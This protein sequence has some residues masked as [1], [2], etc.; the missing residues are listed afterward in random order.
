MKTKAFLLLVAGLWAL[1]V[2]AQETCATRFNAFKNSANN[3]QTYSAA[4]A[5]LADILAGSCAGYSVKTYT[6][7]EQVLRYNLETA[8]TEDAITAETNTLTAFYDAWEKNF[9]GTGGIQKKALLLKERSLATNDEVFKLLDGAFAIHKTS[10]TDYNVLELYFNLYLERYKAGDKNIT[11]DEF[12]AKFGDMAGQV[13]YAQSYI[14]DKKKELLTKKETQPLED[15]EKLF[16]KEAP[17]N[18]SALE[19]VSDNMRGQAA[20]YLDCEKL[21]AYYTNLYEKNKADAVWL[22][23]MV[24]VLSGQKCNE[25][26]VLYNGASELYKAQPSLITALTLG[27]L[28]LRKDVK[29]AAGYYEKALAFEADSVGKSKIYLTLANTL[30]NTDKAATKNYLLKAA[31]FNPKDGSPYIQLA[32]MYAAGSGCQ[33]SDFEKK[34]LYWLAIDTAKK[35][36]AVQPKYKATVDSLMKRYEENMPTKADLKAVNKDKGDTITFGCWINETITVPK[37]K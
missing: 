26:A 29:A 33:F 37:V 20:K 18:L 19:A 3:K 35:A 9:P 2:N 10:F 25:S 28:N 14:Q 32:E 13:V 6:L 22:T 34:A 15:E 7:G 23:G 5:Q 24:T 30:R 36:Q 1:A 21:E 12:I 8:R 31:E 27:R 11:Q 4:T 16:L 17:Q